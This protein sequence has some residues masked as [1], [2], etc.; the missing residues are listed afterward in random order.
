MNKEKRNNSEKRTMAMAM[1]MEKAREEEDH[2][3]EEQQQG[4]GERGRKKNNSTVNDLAEWQ[5]STHLQLWAFH[6]AAGTGSPFSR[7]PVNER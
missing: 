4:Q 6:L 7:W 5:E 1:V 2:E 3:R